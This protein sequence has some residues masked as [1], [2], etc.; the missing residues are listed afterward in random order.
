MT[1]SIHAKSFKEGQTYMQLLNMAPVLLAYVKIYAD[2]S[3][4]DAARFAPFIAD[5][6][7]LSSL[8]VDGY[9]QPAYFA[10][11]LGIAAI[12]TIIC[13]L[14]TSRRLSSEKLLDEV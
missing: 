5:I 11:S 14:F 2:S 8:L 7:S 6:E 13:I 10:T 12:G 3:L 4:P 9:V 1:V